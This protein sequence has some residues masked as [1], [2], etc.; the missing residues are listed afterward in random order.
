VGLAKSNVLR[1]FDSRQDVLLQLLASSSHEWI[2]QLADE[3]P[4]AI[5][6]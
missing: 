6:S 1:H 2:T 3:L 4:S 5:K